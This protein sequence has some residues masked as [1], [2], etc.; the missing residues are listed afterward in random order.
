MKLERLWSETLL[1]LVEETKSPFTDPR[2]DRWLLPLDGRLCAPKLWPPSELLAL[3][4]VGSEPDAG[5]DATA[6]MSKSEL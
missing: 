3:S 5:M 1:L 2:G 4:I 6:G